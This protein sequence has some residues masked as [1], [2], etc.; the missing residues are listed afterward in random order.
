VINHERCVGMYF[1]R[2]V[3]KEFKKCG[4]SN[5]LEGSKDYFIRYNDDEINGE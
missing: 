1:T 2:T 3:R 5:S 4:I